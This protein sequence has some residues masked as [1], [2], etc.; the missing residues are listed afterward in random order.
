MCKSC[1]DL[2]TDEDLSGSRFK[3]LFFGFL[4]FFGISLVMLLYVQPPATA[5]RGLR[6]CSKACKLLF[7]GGSSEDGSFVSV[8]SGL[9]KVLLSYSQCLSS[10]TRFDQVKWPRIF[11]EFMATLEEMIPDVFS[12]LPAECINGDRE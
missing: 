1:V 12:V 10:M 9:F 11:V 5:M 3:T 6:Q 7:G 2:N 8:V 4:T